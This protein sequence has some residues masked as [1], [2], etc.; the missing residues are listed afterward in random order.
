MV[1]FDRYGSNFQSISPIMSCNNLKYQKLILLLES[2]D[3]KV[4]SRKIQM[5]NLKCRGPGRIIKFE[6]QK[7][8]LGSRIQTLKSVNA[9]HESRIR[10]FFFPLLVRISNLEYET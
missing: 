1:D 7:I 3:S 5:P 2:L 6:G 4:E 10:I 9:T 8:Q